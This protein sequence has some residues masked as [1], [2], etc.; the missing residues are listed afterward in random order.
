MQKRN[1]GIKRGYFQNLF[2]LVPVSKQWLKS[3]SWVSWNYLKCSNLLSFCALASLDCFL[4]KILAT[5]K[6]L[7]VE[8]TIWYDVLHNWLLPHTG[9]DSPP[10]MS[11]LYLKFQHYQ[12][13]NSQVFVNFPYS[14]IIISCTCSFF[15]LQYLS[16]HFR[17]PHGWPSWAS[18]PYHFHYTLETLTSL[19]LIHC[20]EM[21]YM[22][23]FPLSFNLKIADTFYIIGFH[24]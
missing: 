21:I 2:L 19:L 22:S 1:R 16:I 13:N 6:F 9:P 18:C 8:S 12:P 15:F 7:L 11:S 24:F 14:H 5:T 3:H 20:R 4:S 17:L 10:T 23:L